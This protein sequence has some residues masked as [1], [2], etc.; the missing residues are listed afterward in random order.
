MEGMLYALATRAM[1]AF[2]VYQDIGTLDRIAWINA[3]YEKLA[4]KYTHHP[5]IKLLGKML[6][7]YYAL[8]AHKK[9]P[10]GE[11]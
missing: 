3:I 1:H 8:A 6:R 10:K 5:E 9:S 4:Q 2:H 11:V 7:E